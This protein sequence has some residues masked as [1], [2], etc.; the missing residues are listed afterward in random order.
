[1]LLQPFNNILGDRGSSEMTVFVI[2]IGRM[3]RG[4]VI[5]EGSV[6]DIAAAIGIIAEGVIDLGAVRLFFDAGNGFVTI[7]FIGIAVDTVGF[8]RAAYGAFDDV[9]FVGNDVFC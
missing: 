6:T 7:V 8:Q 9:S 2:I 1:M 4:A 3:M 5:G